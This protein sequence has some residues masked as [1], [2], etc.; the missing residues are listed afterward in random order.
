MN[1]FTT[2]WREMI[3]EAMGEAGETMDDMV[4]TTL[5]DA[6]MDAEFDRGFGGSEGCAF[7]LWTANRVYFPVVYDGSEWVGSVPRNPCPEATEH[8][9]GQ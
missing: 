9:G 2:C 3:V 5:T 7:T 4:A 8:Q 1:G 6:E